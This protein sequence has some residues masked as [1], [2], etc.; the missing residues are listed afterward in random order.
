MKKALIVIISGLLLWTAGCIDAD[1]TQEGEFNFILKYGVMAKNEIDTFHNTVTKDLIMDPSITISLSLT[2]GEMD[3]IY[4][5]MVEIDFFNYPDEF[6]VIVPEGE[7]IHLVTPY[8]SYYFRVEKDAMVKE[9]KWE[10]E[11]MNPDEKADRLRE[12]ISLIRDIVESRPEYQVL[13]EPSGG[14]L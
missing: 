7:L 2:E 3:E 4:Q 13:P 12:L 10:D 9:L 14:Y 5:K 11:I 8:Y 6:K 1:T